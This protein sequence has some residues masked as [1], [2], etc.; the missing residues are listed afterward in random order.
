LDWDAEATGAEDEISA[1]TG[2]QYPHNYLIRVHG[3]H[4]IEIDS[5]PGAKR[6]KVY[7]PSGTVIDVDNAGNVVIHVVKNRT[8]TIDIDET[9]TIKGKRQTEIDKSDQLTVKGGMSMMITG[10]SPDDASCQLYIKGAEIKIDGE[11]KVTGE[12][13]AMSN[14]KA[15][16]LSTH[17]HGQV[18]TG[19]DQ[20]GQPV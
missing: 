2:S 11:L 5:T 12:V 16:K 3:G 13:T 10:N 15:T 6:Y 14:G 7:H 19:Y 20:T 17:L 4:V 9:V 1:A 18:T 8:T